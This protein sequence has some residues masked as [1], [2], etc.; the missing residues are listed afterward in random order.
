LS[1]PSNLVL[2]ASRSDYLNKIRFR[3]IINNLIG[4]RRDEYVLLHQKLIIG[5]RINN[6]LKRTEIRTA[7]DGS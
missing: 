5:L 1:D 2:K 7:K 6:V 3:S 4:F